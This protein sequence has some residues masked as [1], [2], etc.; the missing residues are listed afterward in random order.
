MHRKESPEARETKMEINAATY[1]TQLWNTHF[2]KRSPVYPVDIRVSQELYDEWIA[3]VLTLTREITEENP[4]RDKRLVFKS[5]RLSV[6]PNLKGAQVRI[7]EWKQPNSS[8][9]S[10][11]PTST[12][13]PSPPCILP[14]S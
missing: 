9:P 12:T 8:S 10:E 11:Q 7:T 1:L 5:G 2:Y 6:D 14:S 4:N 13:E 3:G